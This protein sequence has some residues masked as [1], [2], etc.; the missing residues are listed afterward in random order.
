MHPHRRDGKGRVIAE[1]PHLGRGGGMLC[2]KCRA[3]YFCRDSVRDASLAP[4]YSERRGEEASQLQ[5]S[6]TREAHRR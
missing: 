2:A 3:V 1:R 5:S 6:S 4:F